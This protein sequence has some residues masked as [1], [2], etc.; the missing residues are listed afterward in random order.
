MAQGPSYDIVV[1]GGGPAGV[2][3]AK[4]AA[5]EGVS[6]LLLEKHPTIMANKPCGEAVSKE[7]LETFPQLP[8]KIWSNTAKTLTSLLFYYE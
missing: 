1:V 3:S 2:A 7:T 8:W 4:A 6:I 5:R